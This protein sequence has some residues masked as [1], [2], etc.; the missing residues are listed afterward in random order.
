M[1]RAS[2]T[3]YA[4]LSIAAAVSTILLKS[5]AYWMTGSVGL[6]SD[7]LESTVNLVGAIFALIMLTIAARPPDEEHEFGYSKAEYFSSGLE[8]GLILLAAVS[9]GVAAIRRLISPQGIEQ[10][11]LGL[12]VSAFAS[13]INFGVARVLLKAGKDNNS[14]TLEA[15]ARH[16]FTDVWTSAGVIVG[17]GIVA[18]TG[19]QRLDPV[20]A[21]LMAVN[22]VVTG[23]QL[24]RRSALG[25]LDRSL[26]PEKEKTLVG[27]LDRYQAQGIEFHA[28]R[29]RQAGARDF[30]SVHILVPG[31][32]T[33]Q[34]GHQLLEN[35]ESEVREALPEASIFTHL[36]PLNDP[37]SFA[38]T[39]LDRTDQDEEKRRSEL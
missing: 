33:V 19:L 20:I 15:D 5:A 4:W 39:S 7:A 12:A 16:L 24:I 13:I 18:A 2:L 6:L 8:G 14:I 10:V 9:I 11:G 3:R 25:L 35:L 31:N 28:L 21:I 27:I 36:E 23:V 37:V 30:V 26:P 32:W 29:T 34:K 38:D 22:I 1:N 17:V